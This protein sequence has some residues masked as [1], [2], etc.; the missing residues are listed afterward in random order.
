[1]RTQGGWVSVH[2]KGSADRLR[3]RLYS[4][5]MTL[6]D[7]VEVSGVPAGWQRLALGPLQL[8]SLAPGLYFFTVQAWRGSAESP[9][10]APGRL[11]LIH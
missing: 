4:P 11:V 1:M 8:Q 2:L 7:T 9:S 10:V 6:V 3:L 5:A